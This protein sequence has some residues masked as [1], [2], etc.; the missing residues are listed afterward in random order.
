M[1]WNP[2]QMGGRIY[3]KKN[4]FIMSGFIN[5]IDVCRMRQ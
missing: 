3:E 5:G 4:D 1:K 2:T